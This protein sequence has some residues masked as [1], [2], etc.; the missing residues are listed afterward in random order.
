[1]SPLCLFVQTLPVNL[2][3]M[4]RNRFSTQKLHV[5][6]ANNLRSPL[7][8]SYQSNVLLKEGL[9]CSQEKGKRE[10]RRESYWGWMDTWRKSEI[11]AGANILLTPMFVMF[12][13][14][15]PV[16]TSPVQCR[17]E[18]AHKSRA[19]SGNTT[20]GDCMRRGQHV[21]EGEHQRDLEETSYG[22]LCQAKTARRCFCACANILLVHVLSMPTF[23]EIFFNA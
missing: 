23:V 5:Q 10:I 15:G 2:A 12:L 14:G 19:A 7:F 1:L 13:H 17:R 8:G 20:L 18:S 11:L 22:G 4:G 16:Q 21:Q 3:E 9:T 6:T